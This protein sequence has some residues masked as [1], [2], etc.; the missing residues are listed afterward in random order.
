MANELEADKKRAVKELLSILKKQYKLKDADV[1]EHVNSSG[2]L[3]YTQHD[4]LLFVRS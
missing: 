3:Y 2:T 4:N 1:T